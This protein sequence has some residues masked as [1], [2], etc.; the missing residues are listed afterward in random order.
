MLIAWVVCLGHYRGLSH[1]VPYFHIS[2]SRVANFW[3]HWL[4][5]RIHDSGECTLSCSV[6]YECY[7]SRVLFNMFIRPSSF[8]T[9]HSFCA[10]GVWR[11]R[12]V[13]F[14][15]TSYHDDREPLH[16]LGDDSSGM[17]VAIPA[18]KHPGL[19][20]AQWPEKLP[21]RHYHCDYR[22]GA[23]RRSAEKK[24]LQQSDLP[25]WWEWAE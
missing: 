6:R 18:T 21:Y 4:S 17:W 13:T 19:R 10:S 25:D 3:S 1:T 14:S 2:L 5:R 15:D 12:Y 9:I 20:E 22:H 8:L 23:L 7:N 11:L 16:K 24:Q